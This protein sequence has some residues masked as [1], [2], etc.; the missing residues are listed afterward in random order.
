MATTL[1]GA[2]VLIPMVLLVAN[3]LGAGSGRW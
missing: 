2:L 3:I 1:I